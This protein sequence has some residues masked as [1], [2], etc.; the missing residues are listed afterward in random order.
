[1]IVVVLALE[2]REQLL[3]RFAQHVDQYVEAAAMRHAEHELLDADLAAVLNQ[4]R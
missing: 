2:L 1:M 4:T 3:R